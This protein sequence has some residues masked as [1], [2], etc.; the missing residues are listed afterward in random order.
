MKSKV[1]IFLEIVLPLV[2]FF[3]WLIWNVTIKSYSFS[4]AFRIS[5]DITFIVLILINLLVAFNYDKLADKE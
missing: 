1:F 2:F 4:E 3:S 5:T